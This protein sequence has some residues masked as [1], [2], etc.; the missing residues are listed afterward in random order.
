[1]IC[2]WINSWTKDKDPFPVVLGKVSPM[3][4][5][6]LLHSGEQTFYKNIGCQDYIFN[7]DYTSDVVTLLADMCTDI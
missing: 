4:Y 1:M 3:L 7:T 5:L 6:L 2:S